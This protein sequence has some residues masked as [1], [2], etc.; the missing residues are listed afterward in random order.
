MSRFYRLF[1]I[2]KINLRGDFIENLK[3][4]FCGIVGVIG[5][6]VINFLGGWDSGIATLFVC[7]VLDYITGLIVAGIFKNSTKTENGAL[8]SRAGLKGLVR[9]IMMI[10]F[11]AIAYRIDILMNTDY[12]RYTVIIG[13]IC[14]EVISLIENAGL[15]GVPVPNVIKRAID[16][17][18]NKDK[19]E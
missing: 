1:F 10:A 15:M 16:V 3:G 5:S 12:I 9:K 2:I 6:L 14:N 19:G 13:F 7:I 17:L 11:V 4:M 18:K 8:E